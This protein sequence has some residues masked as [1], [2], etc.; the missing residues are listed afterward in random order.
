MTTATDHSLT[1]RRQINAPQQTVFDAWTKPEHLKNW[2]RANPAWSTEI[3]ELDLQV[4][5][6]YRLGMRDPEQD[7]PFVCGGEFVEMS[8]PDKI[9]YT[10][11]WETPGM[12]AGESLVTVE[13]HDRGDATE[14]VLTHER[15]ANAELAAKHN[16]GWNACISNLVAALESE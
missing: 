2:W 12:D 13:F 14:L 7:G 9:V 5:G 8:P 16:E 15:F 11:S 10:W 6:K 1:I 4:G 3:A